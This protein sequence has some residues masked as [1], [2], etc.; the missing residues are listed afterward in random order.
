[1][2]KLKPK[3]QHAMRGR[4]LGMV[5]QEPLTR[6]NPL[7]RISEHFSETLKTHDRSISKSRDRAA[8]ARGAAA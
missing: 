3:E 4:D 5:F 6:L 1:M 2:L 7:M 8:V